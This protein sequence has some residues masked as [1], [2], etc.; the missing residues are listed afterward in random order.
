[1]A[2]KYRLMSAPNRNTEAEIKKYQMYKSQENAET[3]GKLLIQLFLENRKIPI[4]AKIQAK[5]FEVQLFLGVTGFRL[6]YFCLP[7]QFSKR[8]VN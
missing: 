2:A 4:S 5:L 7:K 3:K 6:I 1:M 8:G